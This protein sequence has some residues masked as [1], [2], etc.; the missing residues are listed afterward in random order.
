MTKLHTQ[1]RSGAIDAPGGKVWLVGVCDGWLGLVWAL[2]VLLLLLNVTVRWVGML[3]GRSDVCWDVLRLLRR[4]A[5]LEVRLRTKIW[6]G[7]G[8]ESLVALGRAGS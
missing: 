7:G 4:V 1:L 8:G 2:L 6:A 3:E 5:M